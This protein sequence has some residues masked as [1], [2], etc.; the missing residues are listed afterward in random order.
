MN[1]HNYS[2]WSQFEAKQSKFMHEAQDARLIHAGKPRAAM[3]AQHHGSRF[4]SLAFAVVTFLLLAIGIA[5]YLLAYSPIE[6]A[7]H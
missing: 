7:L 1:N 2:L 6:F 3:D 5:L 4:V